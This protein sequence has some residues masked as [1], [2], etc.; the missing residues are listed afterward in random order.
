MPTGA[1]GASAARAPLAPAGRPVPRG[2]RASA[3][4]VARSSV[5]HARVAD[6]RVDARPLTRPLVRDLQPAG[7]LVARRDVAER[8]AVLG[9]QHETDARAREDSSRRR[10]RH[11]RSRPGRRYRRHPAGRGRRDSARAPRSRHA[12]SPGL[13][14]EMVPLRQRLACAQSDRRGRDPRRTRFLQRGAL[15]WHHA[16]KTWVVCDGDWDISRA[17]E[18]ASRLTRGGHAA[19]RSCSSTSARRRSSMPGPSGQLGVLPGGLA[20][21][22]PPRCRRGPGFVHDESSISLTS[23]TSCPS[24]PPPRRRPVPRRRA[25]ARFRAPESAGPLVERMA[26]REAAPDKGGNHA[27]YLEGSADGSRGRRRRRARSRMDRPAARGAST[28]V[29]AT[30]DV[31]ARAGGHARRRVV[32]LAHDGAEFAARAAQRAADRIAEGTASTPA[33]RT[34]FKSRMA[35]GCLESPAVCR[36]RAAGATGGGWARDRQTCGDP[37]LAQTAE[38]SRGLRRSGS[39]LSKRFQPDLRAGPRSRS[40]RAPRPHTGLLKPVLRRDVSGHSRRA[41]DGTRRSPN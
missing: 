30:P 12:L 8:V 22:S 7:H 18:L 26:Q 27:Q 19:P 40:L 41:Y 38:R 35:F 5:L 9:D 21:G 3:T 37:R 1:P 11:A 17:D 20:D 23:A 29:H 33:F 15:R 34:G 10:V 13:T 31:A 6:E 25:R 24:Q 14:D 4:S 2:A 39:R 16:M 32:T 36:S 28:A